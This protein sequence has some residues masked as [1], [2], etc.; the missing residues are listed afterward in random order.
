M[1]ED[2]YDYVMRTSSKAKIGLIPVISC[3][4]DYGCNA[5]DFTAYQV[6]NEEYTGDD[7]TND[8]VHST[9]TYDLQS[10]LDE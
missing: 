6:T 2:P 4:S 10:L 9:T 1:D 7:M 3:S 5:N 8:Q